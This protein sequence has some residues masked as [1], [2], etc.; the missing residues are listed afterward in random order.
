MEPDLSSMMYMS[1]GMSSPLTVSP[2]Q[3]VIPPEP[4]P[5]EPMPPKPPTPLPSPPPPLL[6]PPLPP[7]V[8]PDPGPE[9]PDPPVVSVCPLSPHATATSA[10]DAAPSTAPKLLLA[11]ILRD[12]HLRGPPSTVTSTA[13]GAC[14]GGG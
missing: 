6:A 8:P 7:P 14:A 5:P 12:N 1:S 10:S 9:A 13:L 4:L 11:C 2:A 3:A